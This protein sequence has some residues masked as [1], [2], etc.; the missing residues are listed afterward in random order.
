MFLRLTKVNQQ[1]VRP[2]FV[3]LRSFFEKSRHNFPKHKYHKLSKG[4][5]VSC[6]LKVKHDAGHNV[7]SWLYFL[8]TC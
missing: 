5:L 8:L 1:D 6:K 4:Q 2:V 7:E 3:E